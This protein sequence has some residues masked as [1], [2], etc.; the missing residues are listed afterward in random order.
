MLEVIHE[1]LSVRKVQGGCKEIPVDCLE[2]RYLILL[3]RYRRDSQYF[4]EDHDLYNCEEHYNPNMTCSKN[5]K[6]S[7]NHDECPYRS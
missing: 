6:K 1:S 2:P 3:R 4:I 7:S 5:D